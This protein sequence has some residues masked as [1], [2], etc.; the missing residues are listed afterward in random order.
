MMLGWSKVRSTSTSLDRSSRGHLLCSQRTVLQTRCC[1][2]ALLT[3]RTTSPKDPWPKSG[4]T[5]YFSRIS[6]LISLMKSSRCIGSPRAGEY[7]SRTL[8]SSV[9]KDR[10]RSAFDNGH[11]G[12][13]CVPFAALVRIRH[14]FRLV[15][16]ISV[17]WAWR[18]QLLLKCASS[19]SKSSA[20]I[21]PS[22]ANRSN[23][24]IA[25]LLETSALRS[26]T[27][28]CIKMRSCCLRLAVKTMP[29]SGEETRAS[30][31][32]A[33]LLELNEAPLP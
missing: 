14:R 15:C 1:F 30:F 23:K 32:A 21:A 6:P 19:L 22:L 7:C 2:V 18:P 29:V 26:T 10:Q 13:P 11:S 4:P 25:V 3:R 5:V 8:R 31:S 16:I 17:S 24:L 27:A 12:K 20:A 28:K 9:G 33:C